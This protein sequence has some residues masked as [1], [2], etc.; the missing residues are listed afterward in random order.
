MKAQ[1]NRAEV[2]VDQPG[3]EN[4][5]PNPDLLDYIDRVRVSF[6]A[7]EM[8]VELYTLESNIKNSDDRGVAAHNHRYIMPLPVARS[9]RDALDETLS[10][11]DEPS[12]SEKSEVSTPDREQIWKNF[13]KL[14]GA[15]ADIEMDDNWLEDLRDGWEERLSDIYE[16]E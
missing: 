13:E 9:F 5:D 15:W 3:N 1:K 7:N 2:D 8:T 11:V 12:F 6:N 10:Q 14:Y 4:S 16:A